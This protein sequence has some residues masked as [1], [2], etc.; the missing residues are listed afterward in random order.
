MAD[1]VTAVDAP[2][3]DAV[4]GGDAAPSWS[5]AQATA[6]STTRLASSGTR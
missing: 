3:V 6:S 4:E 5:V 1:A 2:G